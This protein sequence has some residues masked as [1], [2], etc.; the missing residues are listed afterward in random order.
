MYSYDIVEFLNHL[1]MKTLNR[2]DFLESKYFSSIFNQRAYYL[3]K[4]RGL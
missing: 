1:A 4:E 2:Y 3:I